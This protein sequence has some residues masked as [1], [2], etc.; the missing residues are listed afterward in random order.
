MIYVG[1][2]YMTTDR[3]E[4]RDMSGDMTGRA[5]L[6]HPPA[7]G[8]KVCGHVS[9]YTGRTCMAAAQHAGGHEWTDGW[10]TTSTWPNDR[11]G[12]YDA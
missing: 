2:P 1:E 3:E 12:A 4:P 7:G 10:E 5:R 8:G 9:P 11:P 6:C